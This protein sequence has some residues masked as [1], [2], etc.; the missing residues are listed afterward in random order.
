MKAL[1]AALGLSVALLAGCAAPGSDGNSST[2]AKGSTAANASRNRMPASYSPFADSLTRMGREAFVE[3]LLRRMTV[4]ERVDQL[5][6]ISV[7]PD[8]PR[9][10]VLQEIRE[11][12]IGMVFNTVVRHDIRPMQ[13][14][15]AHNR[16]KIPLAFA[17]DVIH[18]HRTVF[19]I[20][21]GLASTWDLQ[22]IA[23]SGRV[24][25]I[26][27]AAD[28]LNMTFSPVVD[29]TRDP[30]WGRSSE[31]FGE[32]TY[33][34]SRI[35]ETLVHAYQG[36]DL[37]RPDSIM[38]SVK[39]FAAYGA[40]EGGRDYNTVDMSRQRLFQDYLPPYK[41]AVDAGA[42]A[43]MIALNSLNGVPATSDR[44]LLDDLLR[45]QWD[46]TGVTISDHGA[47]NELIKHGVASNIHDAA[48]AAIM[49]GVDL[50]MSDI[51]YGEQLPDM[52]AKGEIDEARINAAARYVLLMKYDMGLF[53]DAFGRLGKPDDP[54][55]DTNAESRL[56]RDDARRIAR[57]S[58]V[59]LKNDADILPLPKSGRLAVIGPL[60]KSKR[61][62]MG[63]WSAAGVTAQTV[64][65]YEGL[66][67][68]G[69]AGV[70]LS[71]AKGANTT[72]DPAIQKYL[73][74]YENDLEID[75]RSPQAM[76][77]EAV[78][79]AKGSDVILAVVG[80][81]H[82]MAHEASSR[83]NIEIPESQRKL[84]HALK[85]TGKPL[86]IV[87]MNGRPLALPWEHANATA[88][89]ETWFAGTEGGNAIADVL[90]G[91]HNPSG[92]L[93]TTFPRSVGQI[94]QYYGHLNTG[95]PFDPQRPN[96]YTSRYFDEENG[97]VYPFG[98]GLSY[99]RFDVSP[100]QLSS[101]V[102]DRGGE[103]RAAVTVTNRGK[104]DGATTVQLYTRDPVASQS[105]PVR[106]LKGFQKVW[107]RAGE[108]REVAFT[109]RDSDLAFFDRD[110]RTV[111]ESGEFQVFIGLDSTTNNTNVFTLR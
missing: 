92:K 58:L 45:K 52:L 73:T 7:G 22:A 74:E 6:L 9:E 66:A 82:G 104:R 37:S 47:I 57:D 79:V 71:Y 97:P 14:Q 39:H 49:A 33:L 96:K 48:R 51:V 99:T 27:A 83:S 41:A 3:D 55:L 50:S 60:A 20:N 102:L 19:P 70:R 67:N 8:N 69:G 63:N 78:R 53:H 10:Q 77:D 24:S 86:V 15:V 107:L 4:Q 93:P 54:P 34:V 62:T 98:Y 40:I 68:V 56:H 11:G 36:D 26:E 106:E 87:L 13:E 109:L 43:V 29:I 46:F 100:V 76:I 17:Y 1:Y 94:P 89:L 108:S 81:A 75:T 5:R 16:M 88:I 2:T 61:D 59:L 72:D 91:D 38:A 65:V 30:R 12:R 32:D 64:S 84:L 21:L 18:G 110:A 28:G 105:R 44:W 42:G 80:E 35:G 25:A 90:F 101:A 111:I 95:R 23:R 31:S 85:A 103:I